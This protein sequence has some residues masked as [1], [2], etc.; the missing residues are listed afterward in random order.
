MMKMECAKINNLAEGDSLVGD[1]I[2]EG[3]QLII[4]FFN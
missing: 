2:N 3:L 4:F 1:K